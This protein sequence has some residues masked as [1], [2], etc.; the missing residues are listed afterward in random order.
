MEGKGNNLMQ[1]QPPGQG[2]DRAVFVALS[3][4][5]AAAAFGSVTLWFLGRS[6]MEIEALA[7][8]MLLASGLLFDLRWGVHVRLKYLWFKGSSA[9][10]WTKEKQRR[11]CLLTI[12]NISFSV[13][14]TAA[15]AYFLLSPGRYWQAGI[16]VALLVL[17]TGVVEMTRRLIEF[18]GPRCGADVIESCRPVRWFLGAKRTWNGQWGIDKWV[19]KMSKIIPVGERNKAAVV[20]VV[21]LAFSFLTQGGVV[22]GR[23]IKGADLKPT[24]NRAPHKEREVTS[25]SGRKDPEALAGGGKSTG[26]PC[27]GSIIP[28]DGA[29]EPLKAQIRRAWEEKAPASGCAAW[30][31]PNA[32]KSA[33]IVEGSCLGKPWSLAIGSWER[34]AAILLENAAVAARSIAADHE[35]DGASERI[36]LGGGDFHLVFTSVGPYLLIREQKTDG[37]GGLQGTP[38]SCAEIEPGMEQY[39]VLPPGMAELW[40][41]ISREAAPSWPEWTGR[42]TREFVFRDLAHEK[43]ASGSCSSPIRCRVHRGRS[44]IESNDAGI[45]DVTAL[46]VLEAGPH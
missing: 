39:V 46:A 11:L 17:L 20:L 4:A 37:K 26:D 36:D 27:Q 6:L 3:I 24:N 30:A 18:G 2:P 7:G 35:L 21:G 33:Y 13:I 45:Q 31:R 42:G 9:G 8:L 43:L 5:F 44:T 10:G 29:P 38:R 22:V 1:P 25:I 23:V 28:G 19:T 15:G 41:R 34:G 16:T 14:A 40:I 12:V 32:S